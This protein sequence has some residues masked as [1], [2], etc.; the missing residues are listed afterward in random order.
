MYGS[1]ISRYIMTS[2]HTKESTRLF[3]KKHDY[4]GLCPD[5]VILFE[6]NMLPCMTFDGKVILEK[7]YKV[8]RA[9]GR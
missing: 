4:F 1:K 5:N 6:Q 3:F 2:E 9:P 7:T 8:A